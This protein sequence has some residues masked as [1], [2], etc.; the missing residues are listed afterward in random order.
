[1][2]QRPLGN[3]G[4]TVSILGLGAASLGGVYGQV[5]ESAA[6]ATVHRAFEL[7]VNVFDSSPYYANTRAEAVLGKALRGLPREQYVLC[8]KAGRYG[9]DEFDFSPTR[10]RQS[11]DETLQRLGTDHVDVLQLHD[12]EFGDLD[13]I[14]NESLPALQ[15]LKQTGKVRCV[16]MTGLPIAVF[17]RALAQGAPL[18]TVLSYCHAT[19]FDT[20][21]LTLMHTLQARGIGV[22]NASPGAMGLLSRHGPRDWHPAPQNIR[23]ACAR[24]EQVCRQNGVE[25]FELAV[26]YSCRLPGIATTLCGTASPKEIEANIRAVERPLDRDLLASVQAELQDVRGKTWPQ[27]RKENQ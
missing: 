6:I 15:A 7:G 21:L 5:D 19:L 26:Q 4:L 25:L 9:Q 2:Q 16:G 3:T 8:S 24:A 20:N 14:L 23:D 27:G 17:R 12:V 22:I 10:L 11:L 13:A 1:M 18:D